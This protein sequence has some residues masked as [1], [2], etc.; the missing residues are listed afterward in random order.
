MVQVIKKVSFF[1]ISAFLLSSCSFFGG[2]STQVV[3]DCSGP[4]P[5]TLRVNETFNVSKGHQVNSS[6]LN[7][8]SGPIKVGMD[9]RYPPF[10]T[11]DT[12][13]VPEGISVDVANAFG[14]YLNRPTQIVNTGFG[15]L[16]P[17]LQSGE[18]D[19]VIASMSI[20]EARKQSVDFTDPYF[21][22]KIITLVNRE[23]CLANSLTADTTIE[24][25]LAIDGAQYAGIAAQVSATIPTGYGKTVTE[26]TE[27]ALAIE[28]VAEGDADI[29][30]MSASPVVNGFKANR[31][32]TMIV[33]D[34][35]VS[36]PIGMA[37]KKGNTEL[38]A[39]AN[40]F[41]DTFNNVNG[42]YSQLRANWDAIILV[43][44][45]RF[46]MDFYINEA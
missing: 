25:L 42:L 6:K 7:V 18:I 29:F 19:I 20:T 21:Y 8:N 38:L 3:D 17:S 40:A 41:I 35:W 16:I 5:Q 22:F 15:G 23:F 33:W 31:S 4:Q 39:S 10:E 28:A 11:V 1:S 27:L 34:P 2:S 30:L 46:G 36:S 14:E 13:N 43:Q 9:L 44:L 32:K 12:N 26:Y 37:V 45:E 24:E